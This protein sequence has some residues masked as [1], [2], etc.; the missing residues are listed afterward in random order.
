MVGVKNMAEV[1]SDAAEVPAKKRE[2]SLAEVAEIR[3]DRFSA[4]PAKRA[5]LRAKV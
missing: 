2:L 3:R 1:K 5:K 4:Q